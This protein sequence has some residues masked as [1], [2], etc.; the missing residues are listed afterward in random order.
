MKIKNFKTLNQPPS[1]GGFRTV[2]RFS[3][4]PAPGMIIFDCVLV[5]APDGRFR[6][7][8]PMNGHK[9]EILSL[10]PAVRDDLIAMTKGMILNAEHRQAA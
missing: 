9:A 5:Q 10:S 1:A 2:A 8:G 6:V 4:E 3:I 7:Y